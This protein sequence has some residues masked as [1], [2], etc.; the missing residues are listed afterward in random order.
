MI[1]LDLIGNLRDLNLLS[2]CVRLGL[3]MVFGGT[4][5]FERG[6]RQRAAGLRT[7]MLLCVGSA[8][9]MLVSQFMYASYGVGD[10]A[11]L[12]AQVISGIGFLGAGTIIITR[13]NQ[14]KGLTTA[15]TLWATAC[16]GLAVGVGF[17]ECALVMYVLLIFILLLVSL[18]D[19]RYLKVPTSTSLYLEVRRDIGLGDAIRFIHEIGWTVR[20]VKE[21]PSGRPD[22]L[23]VRMDLESEQ[24]MR[25]DLSCMHMLRDQEGVIRLEM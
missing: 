9:T 6:I 10:P 1:Q 8:S 21:F 2:V 13:R 15:A 18:L 17:Y 22:V 25:E 12:S 5:G 23:A 24:A 4:I 19:N 14:I 11:R 16:M 3:A 7:H 20:D